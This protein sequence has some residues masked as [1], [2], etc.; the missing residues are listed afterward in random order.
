MQCTSSVTT[1]LNRPDRK[2]TLKTRSSLFCR[3]PRHIDHKPKAKLKSR[4]RALAVARTEKMRIMRGSRVISQLRVEKRARV[5]Y[6]V[7][8]RHG[9]GGNARRAGPENDTLTGRPRAIM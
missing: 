2:W 9:P 1:P 4:P 7:P 6:V 5:G 3:L 8:G